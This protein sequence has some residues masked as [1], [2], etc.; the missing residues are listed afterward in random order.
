MENFYFTYGSDPIFPFYRGYVIVKAES[1]GEAIGK[2]RKEY[3]DIHEGFI[4][5]SFYYTESEWQ[6]IK[7]PMGECH[8]IL[9]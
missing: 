4:N 1:L 3:P 6:E 2:Y 8:R 9:E 5:C 7:V